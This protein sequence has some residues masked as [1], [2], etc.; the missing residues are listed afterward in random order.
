M[1]AVPNLAALADHAPHRVVRDLDGRAET[2][3]NI[4]KTFFHRQ[5]ICTIVQRGRSLPE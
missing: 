4:N 2:G 5:E 1:P 3:E